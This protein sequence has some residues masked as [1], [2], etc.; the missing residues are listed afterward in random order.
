MS[1]AHHALALLREAHVHQHFSEVDLGVLTAAVNTAAHAAAAAAAGGPAAAEE[2]RAIKHMYFALFN[3]ARS[4]CAE[5]GVRASAAGPGSEATRSF[6]AGIALRESICVALGALGRAAG[7]DLLIE[8]GRCC[9]RV[10]A[11]WSSA[12]TLVGEVTALPASLRLAAMACALFAEA[13][14]LRGASRVLSGSELDVF[15]ACMLEVQTLRGAVAWRLFLAGSTG[16][17]SEALLALREAAETLPS[18]E[19]SS[20]GIRTAGANDADTG[21][22]ALYRDSLAER[23]RLVH[24]LCECSAHFEEKGAWGPA[25][26]WLGAAV[27]VAIAGA[28]TDEGKGARLGLP[29]LNLSLAHARFEAALAAADGAALP[30]ALLDDVVARVASAGDNSRAPLGQAL[31]ARVSFARGDATAGLRQATALITAISAAAGAESPS[32][33]GALLLA[34][35]RAAAASTNCAPESLALY[36]AAA[37]AVPVSA[38]V[39]ALRLDLLAALT[40]HGGGA[41]PAQADAIVVRASADH[42][43][44]LHTLAPAQLA[45][46]RA[47][48]AHRGQV[49]CAAGDLPSALNWA[50]QELTLLRSSYGGS[51][52]GA[53]LLPAGAPASPGAASAAIDARAGLLLMQIAACELDAK[54]PVEAAA[55]AAEALPLAHAPADALFLLAR[56]AAD[57]LPPPDGSQEL[58]LEAALNALLA[59][60]GCSA[61]HVLAMVDCLAPG[62]IAPA[63]VD[64]GADLSQ[65]PSSTSSRMRLAALCVERLLA[66]APAADG[67]SAGSSV[68]PLE[69]LRALVAL[70]MRAGRSGS[71]SLAAASIH[72]LAKHFSRLSVLPA[73]QLRRASESGSNYSGKVGDGVGIGAAESNEKRDAP[74]SAAGWAA[75]CAWELGCDAASETAPQ[76]GDCDEACSS[77]V[78]DAQALWRSVL[79]LADAAVLGSSPPIAVLAL[80]AVAATLAAASAA[81]VALSASTSNDNFVAAAGAASSALQ[82]VA[83]GRA[84]AGAALKAGW[85]LADTCTGISADL[86][87]GAARALLADA[88]AVLPLAPAYTLGLALGSET[89]ASTVAS[90]LATNCA[91]ACIISQVRTLLICGVLPALTCSEFAAKAAQVAAA[92]PSSSQAELQ[93]DLTS[94]LKAAASTLSDVP[95][96]P[97]HCEFIAEAVLRA[98][99]VPD[100]RPSSSGVLS[101]TAALTSAPAAWAARL[102]TDALT[103]AVDAHVG[104]RY[105]RRLRAELATAATSITARLES[106]SAT[107]APALTRWLA[108]F[109]AAST[110]SVDFGAC[111]R[112]CRRQLHLAPSR[113]DCMPV[114]VRIALLVDASMAAGSAASTPFPIA[115]LDYAAVTAWNHGVAMFRLQLLGQAEA[116]MGWTVRALPALQAMLMASSIA[117]RASSVGSDVCAVDSSVCLSLRDNLAS[118]FARLRELRSAAN[119]PHALMQLAEACKSDITTLEK[120][121]FEAPPPHASTAPSSFVALVVPNADELIID[122]STQRQHAADFDADT[123]RGMAPAESIEEL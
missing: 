79:P 110:S 13:G 26:T 80:Q 19:A 104:S 65:V 95:L 59:H 25:S 71:G 93:A 42:V 98:G 14:G 106:A 76:A 113:S 11:A 29:A 32:H 81:E 100:R 114:L 48:L 50:K 115:E 30:I 37:R 64:T 16:M 5:L 72:V 90:A 103:T 82:D 44:G 74:G 49:A 75:L 118:Q 34:V 4:L 43:A 12:A 84:A 101:P 8:A 17:E 57:A 91:D 39:T 83:R 22:D 15:A 97:L 54:R 88:W 21:A 116:F 112:F 6:T 66:A 122:E 73:S 33:E 67:A 23:A 27:A 70:Y 9:G 121:T 61:A 18:L 41:A 2:A 105:A 58:R 3:E 46:V 107:V 52:C 68:S 51:T 62:M 1:A 24:A 87:C 35:C 102:A 119:A 31:V 96:A 85:P 56:A 47:A 63:R 36:A 86:C 77:M 92:V 53:C 89:D 109:D 38:F 111:A 69:L 7:A 20:S 78:S 123:D 120:S 117:A 45:L 60:A 10:A 94:M 108:A 99:R 55:A 28:G 40:M